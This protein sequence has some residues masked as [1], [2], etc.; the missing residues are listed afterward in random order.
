[1]PGSLVPKPK[2]EF[3]PGRDPYSTF[4]NEAKSLLH[5]TLTPLSPQEEREKMLSLIEEAKSKVKPLEG[6]TDEDRQK[7]I[8]TRE[9]LKEDK[10]VVFIDPQGKEILDQ[11]GINLEVLRKLQDKHYEVDLQYEKTRDLYEK[12]RVIDPYLQEHQA[13]N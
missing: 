4:P 5:Q 6:F 8:K 10:E 2:S 12:Q 3:G 11:A 7:Y 1:M 9:Q 13:D